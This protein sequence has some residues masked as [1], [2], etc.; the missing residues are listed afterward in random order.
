VEIESL[1]PFQAAAVLWEPRAGEHRLTVCA[2]ITLALAHGRTATLAPQQIPPHE[3]LFWDRNADASLYAPSDYA[4]QKPRADIL[5]VGHA[6]APG[7]VPVPSLLA[8]LRVG[9]FVKTLH[10]EGDRVWNASPEGGRASPSRPFTAMP[11]RFERAPAGPDNPIGVDPSPQ[12]MR[13]GWS[14]PN[15]YAVGE[16]APGTI[17]PGFGPTA[18]AWRVRRFRHGR[19]I[20]R[21]AA[22]IRRESGPAPP[23]LDLAF[24]NAAPVDQQVDE[25]PTGAEVVLENLCPSAPVVATRLPPLAP[26]AFHVSK[27]TG[28]SY[29]VPLRCDTLWIDG[30][31]ALAVLCFRGVAEIQDPRSIGR[32]VVAT[33]PE[34]RPEPISISIPVNQTAEIPVPEPHPSH[35]SPQKT[36]LEGRSGLP[37]MTPSRPKPALNTLAGRLPSAPVL[38]EPSTPKP[39]ALEGRFSSASAMS[40]V[41]I[42]RCGAITAELSERRAPRA[43]I[44]REN[45]LSEAAWAAAERRWTTAIASDQGD[46]V[47]AFDGAYVAALERIRGPIRVE[48][49]ARLRVAAERGDPGAVLD[50]LKLQGPA[51]VRIERVW[52]RRLSADPALA[53]RLADAVEAERRR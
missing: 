1:C 37:F 50:E 48:E 44:L 23:S 47:A 7:G 20:A 15:I 9:S 33:E 49:I 8:R 27:K 12:A 24:F 41:S 25:I 2:K 16:A 52:A 3:D 13:P 14:L 34:D 46:L 11:L 35:P 31:N 32:I 39:A 36:E 19:D 18:P 51:M 10:I 29:E 28:L 4:P 17:A 6:H 22:R 43:K 21:W 30:D 40:D 26:R 45:G 53:A 5:L 42:E 38:P